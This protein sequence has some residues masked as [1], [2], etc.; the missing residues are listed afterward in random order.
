MSRAPV[1]LGI[2]GSPRRHGNSDRL[3]TAA[4]DGAREAGAEVRTLVAADVALKHC[5]GCNACSL[6][7]E[8][9]QH[10][11]GPAVYES[12]DAADAII[13]ASPV[14]F[15]GVP[16]VLKALLDRMQPYWAR[17]YVLKRPRPKRRPGAV[18][19]ARGGGDPY[20]AE[21]AEASVRSVL[22]VLDIDVLGVVRAVGVDEPGDVEAHPGSIAEARSLG[23]QVAVEAARRI[24]QR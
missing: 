10:D 4:L 7:G 19:I 3:L 2:A 17:T 14:Y 24:R 1:V 15:A 13:V 11:G 16:S 21:H 9:I 20:G 22:A 12:I 6:A 23:A 5:L 8:C 18:L